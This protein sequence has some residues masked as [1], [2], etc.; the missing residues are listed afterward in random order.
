MANKYNDI[1]TLVNAGNNMGLSNTIKR[2]YGIPL[3]FT[4]VQETY[5]AAVIYAATS[6]LAYVGQTVAVGGKLYII[7][8]TANGTHTVGEGEDAKTYDNYLAEVG[9]KTEGDGNTIELDGQTLKLAGLTGLD[10]SKTYVPSLVNGKLVWA[11]PD[12]STAE[13]QSQEINALKTRTAELEATVNGVE[14][15]EGVEAQEGLV[16]KVAANAQAIADETAA[17][18][19]AIGTASKPESVEGAGD[20]VVATGVYKAIEEA[21]T[22]A[23]AYADANDADTV[24]DDTQVKEDIAANASAIEGLQTSLG[25][26]YTKTEVD[27]KLQEVNDTIAG[28]THFTTQIVESVDDVTAIGVLYLIKDTDAEG[29]DKYNEYLYIEGQGAVLIGDTTTDL[30]DYVTNDALAAAIADFVTTEGLASAIAGKADQIAVNEALALKAN[31]ADVVANSTFNEFKT[32]ND[33]AIATARTGA[34]ADVEAKG[35]AVA[36]DVNT[37]LAKKIENASIAHT[38]ETQGEEVKLSEDGKTLN[39]FV[40]AYT[41]SETLQKIE[42]KITEINGGESAGEVHSA[43]NSYKESNNLRVG[44]IE[45]KNDDQDTA[46]AKAQS[47]ATSALTSIADLTSGQVKTNTDDIT[48]IEGRLDTLETANGNHESR[49]GAN[50]TAIGALQA[51]DTTFTTD[52]N[53]IK[54]NITALTTADENLSKEDARLAGLI[55]DLTNNKANTADVYTKTEVYTQT[56]TDAKISEAIGAIPAVDLTDYAKTADVAATYAKIGDAYTKEEADLAFMTEG[57]VDDR[58]NALIVG[59]DPEG[60]KAITDIVNLVKYVDEN[61]SEIAALI[62]ANDANTAKLAGI[63]STVVAYVNDALTAIVQPKASAE[64]TVAT[65]GTL[66][67]GTINVNKLVQTTGDELILNGGSAI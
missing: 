43:L 39:I 17:R 3:D 27:G 59:A 10:N 54:G 22:R 60:G 34:V 57:E 5:D 37:E 15:A 20:A 63:E 24:Y 18:E 4:S 50:A 47:D 35:Y 40:D 62:T 55:T 51:A 13:G 7:S 58:I 19:A 45:T 61:A 30:S 48:A 16:D 38:S 28:I 25:N 53:T 9:S 41:K 36:A 33:E 46:I 2:D 64:I 8:D 65:D 29:V 31:A 44:A 1:L 32:A 23:K 67:I 6:T 52:I 12:T 11:E 14:A 49:I 26:V 66:S 42:D 56:Q 21:E